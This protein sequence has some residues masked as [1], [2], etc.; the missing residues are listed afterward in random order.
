[1][2]FRSIEEMND[3]LGYESEPN[4]DGISC[5]GMQQGGVSK[6]FSRAVASR[7]I[8]AARS[9]LYAGHWKVESFTAIRYLR[10]VLLA[11]SLSRQPLS[12]ERVHNQCHDGVQQH[13]T[14]YHKVAWHQ[15]RDEC[16]RC[17]RAQTVGGLPTDV[18]HHTL[19]PG[20]ILAAATN[21]TRCDRLKGHQ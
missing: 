20:V 5:T 15:G 3:C 16:M 6:L 10:E 19:E 12:L 18:I 7:L 13:D 14:K 21:S 2:T 11:S 1:M 8:H 4:D 9:S 17:A